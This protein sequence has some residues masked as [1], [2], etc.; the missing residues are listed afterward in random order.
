MRCLNHDVNFRIRVQSERGFE[1]LSKAAARYGKPKGIPDIL[2][3]SG[4]GGRGEPKGNGH[5]HGQSSSDPARP[6]RRFGGL[7]SG[8]GTGSPGLSAEL[9]N[10]AQAEQNALAASAEKAPWESPEFWN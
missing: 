8:S 2:G 4:M 3:M 6:T 10:W 9:A 7:P 1:R 5:G